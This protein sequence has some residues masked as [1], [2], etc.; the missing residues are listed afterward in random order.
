MKNLKK[1]IALAVVASMA[2]AMFGCATSSKKSKKDSDD[3]EISEKDVSKIAKSFA[4]ALIDRD[5]DGIKK[6]SDDSAEDVSFDFDMDESAEDV[7]KYWF[8][9]ATT[10]SRKRGTTISSSWPRT[11]TAT[12]T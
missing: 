9:R 11:T 3:S 7:Y 4:D 1:I 12:G 2:F 5:A 8:T 10:G 6:V